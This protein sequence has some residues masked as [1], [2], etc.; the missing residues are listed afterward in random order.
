L[1][2]LVHPRLLVGFMLL[3]HSLFIAVSYSN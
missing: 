2:T 3:D 1:R